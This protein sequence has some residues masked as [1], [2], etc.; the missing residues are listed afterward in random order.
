ML[1]PDSKIGN[2]AMAGAEINI[3]KCLSLFKPLPSLE[4][5]RMTIGI[6]PNENNL[7]LK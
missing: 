5:N 3:K 7:K 4:L 6:C 2:S 1:L